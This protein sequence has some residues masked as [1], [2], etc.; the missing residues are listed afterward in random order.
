MNSGAA[1]YV[2]GLASTL[3]KGAE[4]AEDAID[5]GMALE[6]LRQMVDMNGEPQMLRRFL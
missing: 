2:S 3:K 6:T 5:S 1:V 4:M